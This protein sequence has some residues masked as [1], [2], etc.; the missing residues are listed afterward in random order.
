[1]DRFCVFCSI[2]T[3]RLPTMLYSRRLFLTLPLLFFVAACGTKEVLVAKDPVVPSGVDLSGQWQLQDAGNDASGALRSSRTSRSAVRV[4]LEFGSNLKIT[5][6]D[7][8]VFVSFD[9]SIVEEYRFGEN[10]VVSVGPISASRVSGWEGDSY[11]IE[12]LDDE[13]DKLI[14]SYR[15]ADDSEMLL[16]GLVLIVDREERFNTMQRFVRR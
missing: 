4:F 1:M 16:R 7:F 8:G 2:R 9:R 5:Q 14:E 15:L 11:V 13:G 6:T 12:T 3:L 10:R